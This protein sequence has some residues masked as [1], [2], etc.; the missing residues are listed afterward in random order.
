MDGCGKGEGS[1][2]EASWR[3]YMHT[4]SRVPPLQ[5]TQGWGTL[6]GNGSHKHHEGWAT[7][8]E[9][10]HKEPSIPGYLRPLPSQ[11]YALEQ[12]EYP[13]QHEMGVSCFEE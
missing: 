6:C 9:I 5:R 10:E 13:T 11:T 4:Q 1:A 7:R 3:A 8:Q 2:E 12:N